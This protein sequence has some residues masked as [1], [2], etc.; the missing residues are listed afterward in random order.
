LAVGGKLSGRLT[1]I[2]VL[3]SVILISARAAA[4]VLQGI[5]D[6]RFKR[7]I[8]KTIPI[9][10]RF[11][12][13]MTKFDYPEYYQKSAGIRKLLLRICPNIN[14]YHRVPLLIYT[15]GNEVCRDIFRTG[16]L[17]FDSLECDFRLIIA[18][19]QKPVLPEC[20]NLLFVSPGGFSDSLFADLRH[21]F[22]LM[23]TGRGF[24]Y[25]SYRDSG[26]EGDH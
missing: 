13:L 16:I 14:T 1:K 2:I 17:R 25:A 15:D 7:T 21:Y 3:I 19:N 8:E 22:D 20:R 24:V 18:D 4:I 11:S 23:A 6:K 5:D 10:T 26:S 9:G 12:Y